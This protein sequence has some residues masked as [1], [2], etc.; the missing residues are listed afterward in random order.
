MSYALFFTLLTTLA[1]VPLEAD[2]FVGDWHTAKSTVTQTSNV[3]LTIKKRLGRCGGMLTFVNPDRS[4]SRMKLRDIL[5][6]GQ[7]LTFSTSFKNVRYN[8]AVVQTG[9]NSASLTGG[10]QIRNGRPGG[11]LLIEE[12]L[13]RSSR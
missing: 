4:L 3:R 6:Q 13:T 2:W 11:E 10:P 7:T 1:L 9:K 8:W 5:V 12:E